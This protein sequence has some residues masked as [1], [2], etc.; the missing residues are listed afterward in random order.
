[1]LVQVLKAVS[2]RTTSGLSGK[3]RLQRS[4]HVHVH[5]FV[6]SVDSRP[7]CDFSV[8]ISAVRKRQRRTAGP[9]AAE[10]ARANVAHCL[11]TVWAARRS[12]TAA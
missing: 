3:A 10:A 1:M 4:V 2:L 8:L 11:Q 7:D 12:S 6:Q 9:V 5:V